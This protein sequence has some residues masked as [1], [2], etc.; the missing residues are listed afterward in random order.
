MRR[1]GLL[2][3]VG[4]ALAVT[5]A[6]THRNGYDYP[7]PP[8]IIDESSTTVPDYSGVALA[9]AP[10]RTTW[11]RLFLSTSPITDWR[12]AGDQIRAP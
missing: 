4:V 7:P 6:C 10:G 1:R 8:T 5:A 9:V 12:A 2:L 11:R 3:L